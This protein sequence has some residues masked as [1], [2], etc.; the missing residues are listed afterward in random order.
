LLTAEPASLVPTIGDRIVESLS[1]S[2]VADN[3][4]AT[5]TSCNVD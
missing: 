5:I 3:V 2:F 1:T 4:V